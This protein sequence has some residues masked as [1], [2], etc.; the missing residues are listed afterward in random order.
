[1]DNKK[2]SLKKVLITILAIFVIWVIVGTV[3]Y[4]R[5]ASFEKPIFS[6]PILTVD[7]GGS[8]TYQ[9]FG[10]SFEIKGNSM[11]EDELLGVTHH[12]YYL[13]GNFI[14]DGLRD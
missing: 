13:L 5:V 2:I 8:G 3:D 12:K 11:P 4:L 10:Y 9:G 6:I 1:M 7:D 14:K